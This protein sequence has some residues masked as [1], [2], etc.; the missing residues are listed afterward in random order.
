MWTK[1]LKSSAN[2]NYKTAVQTIKPNSNF[3]VTGRTNIPFRPQRQNSGH[4]H[5]HQSDLS[6]TEKQFY[7]QSLNGRNTKQGSTTH[8]AELVDPLRMGEGT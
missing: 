8:D 5:R 2:I 4:L 7:A 6:L 1:C 3:E